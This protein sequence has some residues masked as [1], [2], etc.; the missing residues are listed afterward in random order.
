M[1]LNN[2]VY[3]IPGETCAETQYKKKWVFIVG[4]T[5]TFKICCSGY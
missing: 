4:N 5:L 1:Q 3:P 2:N